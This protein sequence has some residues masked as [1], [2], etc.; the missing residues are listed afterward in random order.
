[1]FLLPEETAAAILVALSDSDDALAGYPTDPDAYAARLA[2]ADAAAALSDAVDIPASALTVLDAAIVW[3][4]RLAAEAAL[5]SRWRESGAADG[6]REARDAR[7]AALRLL[8]ASL[9]VSDEL[10][11]L[12]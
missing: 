1:M 7:K 3:R 8:A 5:H 10:A 4:D 6:W 9:G 11:R 12:T 2:S